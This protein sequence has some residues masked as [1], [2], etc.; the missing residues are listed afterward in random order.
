[1]LMNV[2]VRLRMT[3]TRMHVVLIKK[4]YMIVNVT[5]DIVEMDLTVLVCILH[6]I[7][8]VLFFN[9]RK[10]IDLVPSNYTTL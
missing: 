1:M 3:V 10:M 6:S 8:V 9:E 4:D 7:S 5:T 2:T